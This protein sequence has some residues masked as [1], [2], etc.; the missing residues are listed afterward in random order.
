MVIARSASDAANVA[1]R[2]GA[3]IETREH[4]TSVTRFR[5]PPVRGRGLKPL[6]LSNVVAVK[7]APRAG[8][9]IETEG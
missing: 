3:R 9:R 4:P 2:A 6:F 1:P 8:A 7:V 5:S